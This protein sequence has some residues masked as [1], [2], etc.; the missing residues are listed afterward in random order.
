MD[1]NYC[2]KNDPTGVHATG[3]V[4]I[5]KHG[6]AFAQTPLPWKPTNTF[7]FASLLSKT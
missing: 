5:M 6:V 2:Y 3:D 4:P 7:L 1:G